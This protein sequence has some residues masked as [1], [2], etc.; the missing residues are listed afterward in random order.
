MRSFVKLRDLLATHKEFG[1]KLEDIERKL[2]QQDE[3]F[4][5][6]SKTCAGLAATWKFAGD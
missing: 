4:I 1:R 6:E 3:H 5:D 2:G